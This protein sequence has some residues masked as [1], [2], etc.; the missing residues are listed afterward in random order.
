[1]KK[2]TIGQCLSRAWNSFMRWSR[3]IDQRRRRYDPW[4][5]EANSIN[6]VILWLKIYFSVLC[7]FFYF[8]KQ[9]QSTRICKHSC[10]V[11]VGPVRIQFDALIASFS[12]L[13]SSLVIETKC[14]CSFLLFHSLI[15]L[16]AW[17]SESADAV[18]FDAHDLPLCRNAVSWHLFSQTWTNIFMQHSKHYCRTDSLAIS[19]AHRRACYSFLL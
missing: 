16:K 14:L 5:K 7:N 10:F 6:Q 12:A 8:S 11:F 3:G 9:F 17:P 13:S 1:M 15:A 2:V 18:S 19:C 4:D